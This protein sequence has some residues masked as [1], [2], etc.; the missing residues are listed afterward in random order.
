MQVKK[1]PERE[2]FFPSFGVL[3]KEGKIPG[4]DT[5]VRRKKQPSAAAKGLN[6]IV[7]GRCFCVL[8]RGL[9]NLEASRKG[10]GLSLFASCKKKPK[11]TQEVC[12]P[13]DSGDD[14]KLCR[15]RFCKAFRRLMPKPVL[16]TKWRR[17]GFE[18]VQKGYRSADARPMFFRKGII[19]VQAH[20]SKRY[21][22]SVATRWFCR[23]AKLEF[24]SVC[25]K[26]FFIG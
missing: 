13:L 10:N 18:S 17:K 21:S 12:E 11:S 15:K 26:L 3:Q 23:G 25:K 8:I 2:V 6:W 4:R 19:V 22:K 20:S 9:R 16:P 24:C 14:S 5:T 7:R 1:L